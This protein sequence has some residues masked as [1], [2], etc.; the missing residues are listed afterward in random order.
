MAAGLRRPRPLTVARPAARGLL[1][2][3]RRAGGRVAAGGGAGRNRRPPPPQ[4][5]LVAVLGDSSLRDW[6]AGLVLSQTGGGI[7][8][9]FAADARTRHLQNMKMVFVFLFLTRGKTA[10]YLEL[11]KISPEH[12]VPK[13]GNAQA[14]AKEL[15]S[16]EKVEIFE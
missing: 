7:G 1:S 14:T 13:N 16:L 3:F 6:G 8:R 2:L 10:R 11:A 5:R 15:R 4:A 12:L 9:F